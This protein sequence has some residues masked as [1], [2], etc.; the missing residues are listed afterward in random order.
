MI[1][2][3]GMQARRTQHEAEHFAC[4][5][6]EIRT[7]S[8]PPAGCAGCWDR[9]SMEAQRGHAGPRPSSR[10]QPRAR[11]RFCTPHC[12]SPSR[13]CWMATSHST[14][15][16]VPTLPT[17]S[18]SRR[19]WLGRCKRSVGW[20]PPLDPSTH[21]GRVESASLYRQVHS[22]LPHRRSY[23]PTQTAT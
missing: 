13:T 19:E 20:V 3:I 10:R 7:R 23:L 16:E 14:G 2:W 5:R 21:L 12:S 15:L 8:L 9:R 6:E 11:A 4:L 22:L 18:S 1:R 17:P